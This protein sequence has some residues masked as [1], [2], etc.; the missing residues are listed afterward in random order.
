MVCV[1]VCFRR[2]V[3]DGAGS[4]CWWCWRRRTCCCLTAC[5]AWE[6]TGSARHTPTLCSPHG[7]HTELLLSFCSFI[8]THLWKNNQGTHTCIPVCLTCA[9]LHTH[10]N[11]HTFCMPVGSADQLGTKI[12]NFCQLERNSTKALQLLK[13]CWSCMRL[14]LLLKGIDL[15]SKFNWTAAQISL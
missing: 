15:K 9:S 2:K 7:T 13:A 8:Q 6:N 3:K 1:C 14:Q 10:V 4:Q 12:H 11:M 5:H